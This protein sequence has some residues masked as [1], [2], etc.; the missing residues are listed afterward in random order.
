[1]TL[2]VRRQRLIVVLALVA[3]LGALAIWP[4]Q[5]DPSRAAH[6]AQQCGPNDANRATLTTQNGVTIRPCVSKTT[7]R[8]VVPRTQRSSAGCGFLWLN[9][10]YQEDKWS[11]SEFRRATGQTVKYIDGTQESLI[12]ISFKNFRIHRDV[13]MTVENGAG[14]TLT[15]DPD[16][17]MGLGGASSAGG[18]IITDLWVTPDSMMYLVYLTEGCHSGTRADAGILNIV[19]WDVNTDSGCGLDLKIRYLVTTADTGPIT[20]RYSVNM[21]NT[22]IVVS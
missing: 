16:Q 19:F 10:C 12:R 22:S 8:L 7:L 2:S 6:A 3:V 15:I 21:P 5:D 1:M 18:D 4:Y 13:T 17:G 11:V 14:Y 20:G 9:P